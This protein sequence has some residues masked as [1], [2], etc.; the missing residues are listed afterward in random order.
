MLTYP[1][2]E[3]DYMYD[4]DE[5]IIDGRFKKNYAWRD[6]QD[7]CQDNTEARLHGI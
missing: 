5:T 3:Y 4:L 6:R 1:E 2:D 7:A